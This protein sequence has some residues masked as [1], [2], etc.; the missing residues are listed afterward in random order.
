MGFGAR[1]KVATRGQLRQMSTPPSGSSPEAIWQQFYDTQPATA[2]TTIQTFFAA[3][4]ADRTLTNMDTGGQLSDPQW[5]SI[6]NITLDF[7]TQNTIEDPLIDAAGELNDL[8][9][10]LKVSRPTWTLVI[11]DKSYGPYSL[12]TLHGTGG[13]SGNIAV[14]GAAAAAG[15]QY[16]NN[17]PTPGWDY[18]GSLI[19]P[20]KTSFRIVVNYGVPV[21]ALDAVTVDMRISLFGILSRR[22]L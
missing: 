12:T 5:L 1:F 13:P 11:S 14:G 9:L 6:Y 16:A 21:A 15:A 17:M 2:G 4:V 10:L 20:P 8:N 19:I 3:P 22:V 18:K 7:L